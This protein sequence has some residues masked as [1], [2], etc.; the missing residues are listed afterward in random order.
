MA[1]KLSGGRL[2]VASHNAGKVREINALIGQFGFEA[3]SAQSLGLPE[4]EET[5]TTFLANA[6]IK[7]VSA[8][9]TSGLPS[10]A[11]D[12]GL[13]VDVLDGEPGIY[14][15]RWAGPSKD[16]SFAMEEVRRAIEKTGADP[17]GQTARFIC[18]LCLCWPDGHCEAFEG[19]VEGTLTF[20]QRGERGFGYDPVFVPRGHNIT[21]G[22]MDPDRK[23]AM[24]HR[25]NA[26]SQLVE[27]C[28]GEPDSA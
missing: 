7:A 9:T 20:P 2:V 8:A 21:F 17:V 24:S 26:F 3:V 16:F 13:A 25:A 12:S 15:A 22:E 6:E 28:F 5:G 4:P 23:H 1:R 19:Q 10:L 27:N 14:S 11:D 18:A